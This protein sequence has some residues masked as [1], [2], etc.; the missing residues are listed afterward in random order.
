[1]SK[2]TETMSKR[3]NSAPNLCGICGASWD[4]DH[5]RRKSVKDVPDFAD[6]I[7]TSIKADA[8]ER[9]KNTRHWT[10]RERT[11]YVLARLFD[12]GNFTPS[13]KEIFDAYPFG[14]RHYTPYKIWLEQVKWWKAG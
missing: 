5:G 4:C 1:M 6:E 14:M 10:W 8:E 7:A 12:N 2:G 3:I 9:A 11:D 13:P